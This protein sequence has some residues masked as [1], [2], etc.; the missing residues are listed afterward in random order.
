MTQI[1]PQNTH[2]NTLQNILIVDD[3]N[4]MRDLLTVLLES[5]GY[6]VESR[7]NGAEALTLL[8]SGLPL[9]TLILLDLRMP[10][11]DGIA[12]LESQKKSGLL[13][14][15]PVILMTAEDDLTV[16]NRR[17]GVQE[18]LPK[19][20]NVSSVLDAIERRMHLH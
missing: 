3:S 2:K 9:P 12:F 13:K 10:V 17:F 11:M 19:P 1:T 5:K 8:N 15:I 16:V 7:T 4:D 20:L 14:D 18:I 6:S